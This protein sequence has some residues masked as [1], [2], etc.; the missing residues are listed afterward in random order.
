MNVP[1]DEL[2]DHLGEIAPGKPVYV[3]CQSGL[4]SYLAC[5]ILAQD[6]YDCYNFSGGYRFYESV[7]LDRWTRQNAYPCG[8]ERPEQ[9]TPPL[10]FLPGGG[11]CPS[12]HPGGKWV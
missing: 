12:L 8:V 11:V 5:R 4:R 10:G 7:L 3:M 6:G 9:Q 2:R 1:L